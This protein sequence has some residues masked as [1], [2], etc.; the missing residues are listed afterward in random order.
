MPKQTVETPFQKF[1]AF[2]NIMSLVGFPVIGFL[3]YL[4]TTAVNVKSEYATQ[5]YVQQ[6]VLIQKSY[7]DEKVEALRKEHEQL[8]KEAEQIRKDAF[9]HSDTN[10][11]EFTQETKDMMS[12]LKQTLVEVTTKLNFLYVNARAD[13]EDL[14]VSKTTVHKSSKK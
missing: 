1:L 5:T 8:R 3:F 11:R 7:I 13:R 2:A 9:E 12:D 4:F 14:E 10:R 6:Q